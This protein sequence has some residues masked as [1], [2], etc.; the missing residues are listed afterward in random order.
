MKTPSQVLVPADPAAAAFI[1][2]LKVGTGLTAEIK[3]HRNIRFH[4]KFFAL[5]NVAF[6][7]WE[8]S[9]KMHKDMPV[10]KNFDR[11]RKDLIIAAGFY[12]VVVNLKGEVRAEPQSISFKS[13]EDEEFADLYSKVVDVILGRILTHYTRDDLDRVVEMVMSFT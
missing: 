12:D 13:M 5:L 10:Q 3:K 9:I 2:K 4:R 11:F 6:D 1:E 7:A 8:P